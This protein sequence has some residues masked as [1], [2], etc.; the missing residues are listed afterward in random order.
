ML[1]TLAHTDVCSGEFA[2]YLYA[3]LHARFRMHSIEYFICT[4][5]HTQFELS[6][7]R[8]GTGCP[9]GQAIVSCITKIYAGLRACL[10]ARSN[11][12]A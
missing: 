2:R 7:I 9:S 3:C 1:L 8:A 10:C 12:Q 5:L 6:P 4:H 11:M